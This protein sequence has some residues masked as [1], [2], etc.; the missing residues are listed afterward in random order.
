M[1]T[2]LVHYWLVNMRGGEKV[3]QKLASMYP[4]APIHTHVLDRSALSADLRDRE[5]RTTFIQRLPQARRRYQQYL[6]LMPLALEEL[7]MREFDLVISSESGPAKG[8]VCSPT[9]THVC[10]CH[11]PMRYVWD[12]YHDY[13]AKASL[14]VRLAMGPLCHY[15]RMWDQSSSVRVDRYA[16]NSRYVA[17]RIRRFWGRDSQ[18]IAP[19]VQVDNFRPSEE[20]GDFHLFFG[21]LVAYK[22]ADL[23]VEAFRASGRKLVMA[24]K[25]EQLDAL[26]RIAPPNVTFT[27]QLPF[28]EVRRL[29]AQARSL[30]FPGVEDFGIVPVEAMASG[31]PVVAFRAGGVLDSVQ[32][33]RTGILFGEQTPASLNTA[34][35][36][37]EAGVSGLTRDAMVDR[38]REFSPE[39]FEREFRSLVEQAQEEKRTRLQGGPG[40]A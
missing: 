39:R 15:L 6:P 37:L 13:K 18:V 17:E 1:K 20:K 31:T 8:V 3:L 40:P 22:R 29:L 4:E 26:R 7:D 28:E 23:A 19:P 36:R 30:V 32:D 27:G 9:A 2:A 25:G 14:P 35:D 10:Y 16:A 5:F 21:E 11:S 33:G 24:G 38:A 34:L 12:M